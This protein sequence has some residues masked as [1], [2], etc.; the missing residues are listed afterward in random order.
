MRIDMHVHT[1]YSADCN[2]SP[3]TI[4]KIEIAKG[5]DCVAVTDHNSFDSFQHFRTAGIKI[6]KGEEITTDK[7]HLIGLFIEE[8]IRSRNFSDACDEIRSQ[9]GLVILPHP[10]RSHDNPDRLC[11]FVDAIE[12]FNARASADANNKAF[13]LAYKTRI[14]RV[15]GSDA[16]FSSELGRC[17]LD[18]ETEDTENVRKKIVKGDVKL[19]CLPSPL[20]VHPSTWFVKGTK[21]IRRLVGK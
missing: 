9:G 8:A 7:G 11:D 12:V 5:V 10:F 15:C 13:E 16:H 6:I 20:Y 2:L 1:K 3:E 17:V 21:I 19:N 14:A 18:V 4:T